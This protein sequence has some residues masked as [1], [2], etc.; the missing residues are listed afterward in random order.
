MLFRYLY[1]IPSLEEVFGDNQKILH[2]L[3]RAGFQ[4]VVPVMMLPQQVLW[5]DFKGIGPATANEIAHMLVENDL[6]HHG[7]NERIRSFIDRV[8]G[9]FE[10][11]STQILQV[12][13]VRTDICTVSQY[14]PLP[15]LHFMD[16]MVP[17]RSV[18]EL[19]A[20]SPDGIRN[21]TFGLHAPASVLDRLNGDIKAINHRIHWWNE[22]FF[23]G[24]GEMPASRL[25]HLVPR[26]SNS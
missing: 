12:V 25:L 9:D 18:S 6:C 17:H 5:T 19:L 22:N 4:S 8:F 16:K 10:N 14:A 26:A 11:A 1:D 13:H 15:L 2:T 3:Q 20:M 7:F 21:E 23:L 24:M